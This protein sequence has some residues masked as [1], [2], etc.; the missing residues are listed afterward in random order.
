VPKIQLVTAY[1]NLSGS[2]D[3]VVAKGQDTQMTFPESLVLAALHGGAENVHTVVSVGFVERTIAEEMTR[4]SL[5]YGDVVG[6]V[7]P[8]V[9]NSAMM[10]L[11]DDTLP[12]QEEID[13]GRAAAAE[14]TAKIRSRAPKAAA[15]APAPDAAVP[16]LA[17]LPD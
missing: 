14:A 11:A 13:A 5:M 2:P 8:T 16:S 1:I 6:K 7:F 17:D 15:T 3:N 12:T 9:G 4:L 10:Q